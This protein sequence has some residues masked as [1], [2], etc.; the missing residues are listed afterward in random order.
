M[1]KAL[2]SANAWVAMGIGL[3]SPMLFL[4]RGRR[5]PKYR[6]SALTEALHCVGSKTGGG[7]DVVPRAIFRRHSC[8]VDGL[9]DPI[10]CNS[11]RGCGRGRLHRLAPHAFLGTSSSTRT[12]AAGHG[13]FPNDSY[14]ECLPF[15]KAAVDGIIDILRIS[16]DRPGCQTMCCGG[17]SGT[18]AHSHS[19][20]DPRSFATMPICAA[21]SFTKEISGH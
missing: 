17:A 16:I 3:L 11:W 7:A 15:N 14:N 6:L 12:C 8:L 2:A 19:I 21:S 10:G 18:T 5:R 20:P 1:V 9:A 4:F 13:C